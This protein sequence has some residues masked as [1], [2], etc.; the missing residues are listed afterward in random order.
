MSCHELNCSEKCHK[1]ET[2]CRVFVE[3]KD[4]Q[5]QERLNLSAN[6]I[7]F[8]NQKISESCNTNFK[9]LWGRCH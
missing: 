3:F 9:C 1:M 6:N 7:R 2:Y 4:I 5:Q 8:H